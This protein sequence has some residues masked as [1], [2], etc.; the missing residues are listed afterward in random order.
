MF[1]AHRVDVTA[2]CCEP[3][4]SCVD[5][6]PLARAATLEA[7]SRPRPRW[8]TQP[9]RSAATALVPHDAA[10]P[11][12][13]LVAAGRR[14]SGP[15]APIAT[16]M[17]QPVPRRTCGSTR[18][19]RTARAL[20]TLQARVSAPRRPIDARASASATR[21]ARAE[22]DRRTARIRGR[23][24]RCPIAPLWWPHTHGDSRSRMLLRWNCVQAANGSR[25][26]AARSASASSS[27]IRKAASSAAGE[28][29]A[30]LLPRR[31]L[32]AERHRRRCAASR[33]A[34]ARA[35]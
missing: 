29:R 20:V 24:A 8:K 30:G 32:D 33:A 18:S 1:L 26:T 31:L 27:S 4:T 13:R 10:R 11:H 21:H 15:G 22:R 2:I 23:H 35:L 19:S 34:I 25:S 6:F 12:A 3:T 7:A 28:R 14:R 17:P 9:R 16:R 5:L